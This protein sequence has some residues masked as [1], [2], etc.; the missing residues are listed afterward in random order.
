MVGRKRFGIQ[1]FAAFAMCASS[2]GAAACGQ[3]RVDEAAVSTQRANLGIESAQTVRFSH[4]NPSSTGAESLGYRKAVSERIAMGS[5]AVAVGPK[6]RVYVLDALKG[7]VMRMVKGEPSAVVENLPKDCDDLTVGADGAFA[8][9][10]SVKPE[11]LVFAPD[12]TK[13]GAVDTGAVET[14]DTITLGRSRRVVVTSPFQE[15]FSFGSPSVPQV[16]EAVLANK[17]E[18]AAF[19]PNGDGIVGVR[20]EDGVVELRVVSQNDQ[21]KRVVKAVSLGKGSS[22]RIV[23]S[24]GSVVCTRIEHASEGAGGE[25]VVDREAAC[26]DVSSEKSLLRVK[27]PAVGTYVPRHELAFAGSTLV[28]MRPTDEGLDITSWSLEGGAQ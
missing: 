15:T 23:G 20:R 18:G 10:R 21:E 5:P 9:R 17:R 27:L 6:G 2:V 22:V 1:G 25:V 8:V 19:L 28:H 4:G 12:G 7:R 11:V 13:I 3:G 24:N 26:V 14:S 16:G